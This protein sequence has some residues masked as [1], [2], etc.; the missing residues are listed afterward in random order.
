MLQ[1]RIGLS[2]AAIQLLKTW[3]LLFLTIKMVAGEPM[4]DALTNPFVIEKKTV[5]EL[6]AKYGI[7]VQ[8]LLHEL[9]PFAK[10]F[11]RPPISLYHVGIAGLGKS[12]TIYLGVNLEFLGLPLSQAVHGEQFLVANARN[13]GEKELVMIA[14]SAAPCGH[15]RQFLYEMGRGHPFDP[16]P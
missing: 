4:F 1:E 8:Q 10:R 12:G 7:T 2:M 16:D 9:V 14:L 15:C 5:N 3:F 6:T 13:H 11:A